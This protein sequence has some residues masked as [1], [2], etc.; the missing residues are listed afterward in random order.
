MTVRGWDAGRTLDP[1]LETYQAPCGHYLKA[2]TY[3]CRECNIAPLTLVQALEKQV[4]EL[5]GQP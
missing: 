3:A 1:I 4:R 2:G 5:G